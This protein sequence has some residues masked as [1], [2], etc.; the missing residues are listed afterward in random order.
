[1]RLETNIRNFQEQHHTVQVINLCVKFISSN[2]DQCHCNLIC[3]MIMPTFKSIPEKKKPIH[4]DNFNL[5][6]LRSLVG[7]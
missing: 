5:K 7:H 3:H 4:F 2:D 1:M 6:T